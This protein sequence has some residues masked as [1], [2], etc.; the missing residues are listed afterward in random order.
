MITERAGHASE[1]VRQ[2]GLDHDAVFVLG[3]DGTVMEVVSVL[4]GTDRPV[5]V[6]PGG[7]GNLLAGALGIPASVPRSVQ[8]L[9]AGDVQRI[10]LARF[11]TGEYFAVAAGLGIDAAMVAATEATAWKRRFGLAAY[12]WTAARAALQR[13]EFDLRAEVD[14]SLVSVRATLAMVANSGTLFRGLMLLGP[15]ISTHD[16]TLDL[17]VF[18]PSSA[19]DVFG[20]I[21]RV[22]RKDF[23]PHPGMRFWKGKRIR[24]VSVPPRA[25]QA[26]GELVGV[27]PVEIDVAP[28][29]AS[30]LI[31]RR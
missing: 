18:S 22:M 9:L 27:T 11:S 31:P 19:L 3:G 29:A 4:A 6:L 30:L 2:A 13:D 10:D 25:V 26:D 15:D 28:G 8:A 7:T 24:L 12:V 17:C 1:I 16:G 5:G 23:R 14:G 20:I 21:W